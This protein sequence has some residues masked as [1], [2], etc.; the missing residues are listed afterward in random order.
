MSGYEPVRKLNP[1]H[2]VTQFMDTEW[3]K[4]V[5]LLMYREGVTRTVIPDDVVTRF[6]DNPKGH[7]VAI[8]FTD[9]VGIELFL[10]DDKE[11]DRLA[12]KEGGLPI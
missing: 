5:C 12:R 1:N 11:A 2:P 10:V 9:G 8:K 7:N 3:A 4:I 6:A